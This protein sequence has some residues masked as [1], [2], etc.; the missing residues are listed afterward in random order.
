VASDAVSTVWTVGSA[1]IAFLI[2]LSVLGTIGIYILTAPRIYFAMSNDGLFFRQ[3]ATIHPRFKT[4]QYAIIFQSVWTILLLIFWQTFSNL[5]T[6]VVFIDTAFFLLTASTIFIF[7]KRGLRSPSGYRAF[8]YPFTPLV[9][10]L[11]SGFIVVNT[12]IE[13][14]IQAWAGLGFLGVGLLVVYGFKK[15]SKLSQ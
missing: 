11:M 1:F 4:P 9:F 14:P 12:L 13:K 10:M 3:F 5:I 15:K 6:Y 2:T 7:R 8:A